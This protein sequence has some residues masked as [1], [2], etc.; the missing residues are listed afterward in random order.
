MTPHD[1]PPAVLNFLTLCFATACINQ[2]ING[3]KFQL[4]FEEY[5]VVVCAHPRAIESI[6]AR[7]E[8]RKAKNNTMM[9]YKTSY[10]LSWVS[11]EARNAGVMNKDT[12]EFMSKQASLERF[13][14]RKGEKMRPDSC[15]KISKSR[16]GVGKSEETCARMSASHK[17]EVKSPESNQKRRAKMLEYHA[18]RRAAV[19]ADGA[20]FIQVECPSTVAG[21]TASPKSTTRTAPGQNARPRS[22]DGFVAMAVRQ[23][24]YELPGADCEVPRCPATAHGGQLQ[25]NRTVQDQERV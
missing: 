22:P 2:T 1:I 6:I 16:K 8:R 17:G 5:L 14:V 10:V 18:K 12:A 7:Y 23:P 3:I 15:A 13:K 21:Q 25:T 4:T 9:G 11:K 24:Y 20:V 19:N